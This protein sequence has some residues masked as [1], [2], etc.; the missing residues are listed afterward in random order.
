[1]AITNARH[2]TLATRERPLLCFHVDWLE[3]QL[4]LIDEI[5]YERYLERQIGTAAR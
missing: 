4:H 1:M 3:T 2:L 5:G